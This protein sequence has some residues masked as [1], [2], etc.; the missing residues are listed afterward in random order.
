MPRI[1]QRHIARTLNL[2]QATVSRALHGGPIAE[3]T[4]QR[5]LAECERLGYQVHYTAQSLASGRT[6]NIVYAVEAFSDLAGENTHNQLIGAGESAFAAGYKLCVDLIGRTPELA[7]AGFMD[8]ALIALH[9]PHRHEKTLAWLRE[10][11]FPVVLV[12]APVEEPRIA[13]VRIDDERAGFE[14]TGH[15]LGQGHRDVVF[16]GLLE[17]SKSCAARWRGFRR[18][19]AVRDDACGRVVPIDRW[20]IRPES[21][22]EYAAAVSALKPFP[23]AFVAASDACAAGLIQLL[24]KLGLRVPTDVSVV[25][26]GNSRWSAALTPGLTTVDLAGFQVGQ[27]ALEALLRLISGNRRRL[28]RNL[29][30]ELVVRTSC[31][32]VAGKASGRP[33]GRNG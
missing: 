10:T 33:I 14:L 3:A 21:V 23:T 6:Q 29:P 8:G 26:F 24:A 12:D 27:S 15:V 16:F 5:V 25:G 22:L 4:R 19:I 20:V 1:D 11:D 32:A 18:A 31:A 28:V 2:S 9:A 17:Q 13:N 7:A 30:G